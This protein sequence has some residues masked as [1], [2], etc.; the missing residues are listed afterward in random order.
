MRNKQRPFV[1][2]ETPTNIIIS[3]PSTLISNPR[4]QEA[5]NKL[6]KLK[7]NLSKKTTIR[8]K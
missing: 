7:T 4:F 2:Q 3:R 5:K 1:S 6:A 8:N